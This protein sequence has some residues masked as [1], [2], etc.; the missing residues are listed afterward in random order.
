[1][2]P[3]QPGKIR[4]GPPRTI[5]DAIDSGSDASPDGRIRIIPQRQHALLLDEQH[6]TRRLI[7]KRQTDV[8]HAAVSPDG[9]WAATFSWWS[10]GRSN[11]AGI[12][13]VATGKHITDLAVESEANGYF[14]P[15]SRWLTT[16]ARNR[17]IQLWK[18][19]DWQPG[20][21]FPMARGSCWNPANGL[22]AVTDALSVIRLI[23]PENGREL[24]QLTGPGA[25][26]YCP[27]YFS[28]DGARLVATAGD[29]TGLVVWELRLIRQRLKELGMDWDL[30]ELPAA[31][32]TAKPREPLTVQIDPGFLRQPIFADDRHALAVLSIAI[33][34]QPISAEAYLQRGMA[35]GRLKAHKMAT[36]DYQAFLALSPKND[37]RRPEVYLRIASNYEILEDTNHVLGAIAQIVDVSSELIPWP[38][39]FAKLCNNLAW[40]LVKPANAHATALVLKLID[41]AVEVA[42]YNADYLNTY[43]VAMYRIGR[44]P[45]AIRILAKNRELRQRSDP[46]DLYFLAMT[47]AKLGQHDIALSCFDQATSLVK[48]QPNLDK[49]LLAELADF[50]IEAQEAL[51]IV[52]SK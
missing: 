31:P 5:A 26:W 13:E 8:R 25:T 3:E 7:L 38:G 24:F 35:Y 49:N 47:H 43:G 2:D 40:E 42:P 50:R 18:A 11:C 48:A 46:F 16:C 30:P 17:G 44:Y 51:G 15:D 19:G 32:E 6:P 27:A 39:H 23:D 9:R 45:E 1:V 52:P 20:M 41:R 12:W 33:A 37:V 21:Q 34:A 28:A 29:R 22:L 36:A 10:D 14:S 4:V